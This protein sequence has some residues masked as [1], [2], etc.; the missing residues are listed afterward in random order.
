MVEIGLLDESRRN[1]Q[2]Y[3]IMYNTLVEWY[4][5]ADMKQGIVRGGK[6]FFSDVGKW[7]HT[8]MLVARAAVIYP[9]EVILLVLM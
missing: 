1:Q 2:A 5:I 3:T 4:V 8:F 9:F 7:T 6:E